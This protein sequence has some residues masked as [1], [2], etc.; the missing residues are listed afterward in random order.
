[1]NIILASQSP[2]RREIMT[3]MDIPFQVI[4]SHMPEVPPAGATPPELVMALAAQK[5][6]AVFSLHSDACVIGADTVVDVD[7]W[8]LGKPHTPERAKEYLQ[9]L[10]GRS[11]IVYTGLCVLT[12]HSQDVRYCRTDVTF[13]PMTEGEIDWYISTGDPLD[14]AGSYGVQGPA[15]Q[16]VDHLEGNYFNIIGLP[17]PLL[18]EMLVT[19]GVMDKNHRVL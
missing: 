6:Q 8:V 10:Q 19:A 15:C 7:G 12:P 11:H 1:M 14:K 13:R 9:L 3:L 4:E 16:F 2:R 5:A 18:Y 17:A